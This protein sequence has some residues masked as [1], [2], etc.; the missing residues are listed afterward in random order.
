MRSS[1]AAF[2]G[3]K[4][5]WTFGLSGSPGCVKAALTK[6]ACFAFGETGLADHS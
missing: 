4:V 5:H 2:A 6:K 3:P 1:A